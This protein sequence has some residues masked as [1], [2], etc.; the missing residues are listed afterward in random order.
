MKI[1]VDDPPKIAGRYTSYSAAAYNSP[2][3][4][5]NSFENPPCVILGSRGIP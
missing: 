4:Y 1:M 2:P 3:G 5:A